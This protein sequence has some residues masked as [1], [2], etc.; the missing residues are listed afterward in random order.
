MSLPL[1]YKLHEDIISGS[2]LHFYHLTEWSKI[3][4][5]IFATWMKA[6]ISEC[7]TA[8]TQGLLENLQEKILAGSRE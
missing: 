4:T 5:Q 3:G 2:V 7:V 8:S 6:Y 1:E